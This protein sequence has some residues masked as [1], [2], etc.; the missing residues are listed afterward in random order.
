[1]ICP[2]CGEPDEL[3]RRIHLEVEG[4]SQVVLVCLPDD[5]MTKLIISPHP[6]MRG[7]VAR[8]GN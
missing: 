2:F 3:H 6:T 1:M 7:T 4:T 5:R 8:V